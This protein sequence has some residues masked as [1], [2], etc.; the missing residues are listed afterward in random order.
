MPEF[1]IEFFTHL[2]EKRYIANEIVYSGGTW[3]KDMYFVKEGKV[4]LITKEGHIVKTYSK[5]S[6]FGEEIF[7]EDS[8]QLHSAITYNK[9]TVLLVLNETD[10]IEFLNKFPIIN[11][12]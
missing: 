1:I 4:K 6:H 3:G 2:R 10:L 12:N 8:E 9:S 5:G 11:R 7:L